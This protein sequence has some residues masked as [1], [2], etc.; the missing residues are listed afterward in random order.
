MALSQVPLTGLIILQMCPNT[1]VL[2][3]CLGKNNVV[4]CQWNSRKNKTKITDFTV[5]E[6]WIVTMR[7]FVPG[8]IVVA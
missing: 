4:K 3:K 6:K 8:G 7:V 1:R 5:P 2:K